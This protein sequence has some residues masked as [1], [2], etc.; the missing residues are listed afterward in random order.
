MASPDLA[1]IASSKKRIL[2][3]MRVVKLT[4]DETGLQLWPVFR[5][6]SVYGGVRHALRV[7]SSRLRL[8]TDV[9]DYLTKEAGSGIFIE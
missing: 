9:I 5:P 8:A 4:N 3:E 7:P 2:L 6:Q 1:I